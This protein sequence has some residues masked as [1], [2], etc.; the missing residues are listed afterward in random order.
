M[1]YVVFKS[2]RACYNVSNIKLILPKGKRSK[3]QIETKDA[4]GSR[5]VVS[6]PWW[7]I[8]TIKFPSNEIELNP[9]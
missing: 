6:I 4:H 3:I 7:N 1:D 9:N 2:N 5:W 8:R